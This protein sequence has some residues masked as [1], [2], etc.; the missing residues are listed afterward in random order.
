MEAATNVCCHAQTHK[1][2]AAIPGYVAEIRPVIGE[3]KT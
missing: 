3:H 1:L 2:L